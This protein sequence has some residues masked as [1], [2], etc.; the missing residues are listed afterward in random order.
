MLAGLSK[1]KWDSFKLKKVSLPFLTSQIPSLS[2]FKPEFQRLAL[3][4]RSMLE[5][6]NEEV[7]AYRF[8]YEK[9]FDASLSNNSREAILLN[10]NSTGQHVALL[11]R[12]I[13][14][15]IEQ[16]LQRKK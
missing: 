4:I 3:S 8:Y 13:A 14:D 6:Y 2:L 12:Q 10:L 16:L 15:R 1:G 11:C 7:D 9:T 5:T